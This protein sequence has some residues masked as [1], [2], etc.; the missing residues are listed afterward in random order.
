MVTCEKLVSNSSTC[1][2]LVPNPHLCVKVVHVPNYHISEELVL[3]QMSL[4]KLINM[5]DMLKKR[6][7]VCVF[8]AS[9][10]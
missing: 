10:R 4:I 2:D 6:P 1:E 3:N 5:R 7:D 9:Y 8:Q